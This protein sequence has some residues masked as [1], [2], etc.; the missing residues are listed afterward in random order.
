MNCAKFWR[1]DEIQTCP[2]G[3]CGL[4]VSL[5]WY[6]S[7]DP[8]SRSKTPP[9]PNKTMRQL[10]LILLMVS[11]PSHEDLHVWLLR[12]SMTQGGWSGCWYVNVNVKVARSCPILCDTVHEILQA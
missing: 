4:G 2:L 9:N 11:G 5:R 6:L 3:G 1:Y 12:L 8:N 10:K 7:G